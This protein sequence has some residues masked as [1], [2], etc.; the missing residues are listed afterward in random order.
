[1]AVIVVVDIASTFRLMSM[2]DESPVAQPAPDALSTQITDGA[3][4]WAVA[5]TNALEPTHW[6][7]SS[8][9]FDGARDW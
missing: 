8:I 2:P 4:A 9:V 1:M 6:S 7:D 3:S 5:P